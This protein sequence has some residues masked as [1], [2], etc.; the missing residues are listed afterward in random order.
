[1]RRSITTRLAV[2][3]ATVS[4]GMF[5]ALGIILAHAIDQHFEELDEWELKDAVGRIARTVE[6]MRTTEELALLH[7]RLEATHAAH[8]RVATWILRA[9]GEPLLWAAE[10]AY[11]ATLESQAGRLFVWEQDGRTYRGTA[12]HIPVAI[13]GEAPLR[14]L[15]ALD[16][17]HHL[18]FMVLFERALWAAIIAAIFLSAL[19]GVAIARSGMAPIRAM[20]AHARRIST[21]R[22]ADRLD[23]DALPREL[24][25]LGQAFNDMLGRLDDSFRRLSEFSSDIAHELRTPVTNL[26]TETQVMLSKRRSA[27]EYREVL[28]SN[29]EELERLARMT[30]D[31]LFLAKADNGLVVPNRER[32]DLAEEVRELFDFYDAVAEEKGIALS[33]EGEARAE[34]DRLMLRRAINNLLSNA[35]RHTPTG[36]RV[37][38]RLTRAPEA[39]CLAVTNTGDPIP[40]EVLPRLF[41]RFYRPDDSRHRH[42]EGAGLGLAIT[43]SVVA[44]HGGEITVRSGAEGNTFEIRL[45]YVFA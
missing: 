18:S 14:V 21:E 36:G 31:M 43:R 2:L 32:L 13:A 33:L 27:D 16:I 19:L 4:T 5:L 17:E 41:E 44:A 24:L 8:D 34:G 15:A 26:L 9:N 30:A 6:T 12:V 10:V 3:F 35:L 42:S 45:P 37:T 38:V 29:A 1:M 39:I 28:A 22:L 23:T 20:T 11:P 40:A 25:N 7:A